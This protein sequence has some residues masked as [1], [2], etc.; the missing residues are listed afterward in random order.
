MVLKR[1]MVLWCAMTRT[2]KHTAYPK[3]PVFAD[4]LGEERFSFIDTCPRDWE[5]MPRPG[6]PLVV[7]LDGGYVHSS[8]QTSRKDGWFEAVTGEPYRVPSTPT[9]TSHPRTRSAHSPAAGRSAAGNPAMSTITC[10]HAET[11]P[12]TAATYD[13]PAGKSASSE[14]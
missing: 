6:L 2:S 1:V 7:A 3:Q 12:F 5:E 8:Q 14:V 13:R 9:Y 4:E 10:P 11:A